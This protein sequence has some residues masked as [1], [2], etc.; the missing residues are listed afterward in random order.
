MTRPAVGAIASQRVI[1]SHPAVVGPSRCPAR[2]GSRRAAAIGLVDMIPTKLKQ[3]L[4]KALSWPVG[5]EAVSA[6]LGDAPHVDEF[7]LWFNDSPA[8]RASE[9]QKTLREASPY[10]VLVAEYSP[11]FPGSKAMD[12]AGI[13]HARWQLHVNPVPRPW[14]ATVAILLRER[15]LPAVAEWLNTFA[16]DG[17][18]RQHHSL[19]LIFSPKQGTLSRKI[20]NGA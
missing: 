3:K 6:G 17:W 11:A 16:G 1:S 15:G 5:A 10:A 18:E 12:A 7:T 13:N 2:N 9:F 8:W 4:P 20:R 19:E 14:R